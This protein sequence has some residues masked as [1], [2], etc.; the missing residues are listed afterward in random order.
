MSRLVLKGALAADKSAREHTFTP[1]VT[2][3]E[4]RQDVSRSF[5]ARVFDGENRA[6]PGLPAGAEEAQ[7]Q[8][9]CRTQE[10]PRPE[11]AM[12]ALLGLIQPAFDWTWKN[13]LQVAL[14]V[15]L[16]VLVQTVLARWLTPR[17]RYALS[18]LILLRLLPARCSLKSAKPRKPLQAGGPD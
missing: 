6:L 5:L 3:Q 14:L 16:V 10:N 12:K 13:S 2:E 17:L 9:D 1:L 11:D 7:P 18:L 15:G 8:R 4:C